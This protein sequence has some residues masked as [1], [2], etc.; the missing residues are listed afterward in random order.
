MYRPRGWHEGF[1]ADQ[2]RSQCRGKVRHTSKRAATGVLRVMRRDPTMTA[3][4]RLQVYRCRL[5]KH[6]HIGKRPGG[7]VN[8]PPSTDY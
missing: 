5:C 2:Y 4:E 8:E 6:W 1:E 7:P 3:P